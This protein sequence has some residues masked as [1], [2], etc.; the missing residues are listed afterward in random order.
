MLLLAPALSLFALVLIS[1]AQALPFAGAEGSD[2]SRRGAVDGFSE[3][4]PLTHG[5][6][7]NCDHSGPPAELLKELKCH[8]LQEPHPMFFLSE[9]A[10]N[11]HQHRL[12]PI[13]CSGSNSPQV[14]EDT[15]TC[16]ISTMLNYL[17]SVVVPDTE[18]CPP[19]FNITY[20]PNRYPHYFVEV[21]CTAPTDGPHVKLQ[22]CP[23]TSSSDDKSSRLI[24]R[25]G[26]FC[27]S[28]NLRGMRYLTNDP[29]DNGCAGSPTWRTCELQD[30]GIGCTCVHSL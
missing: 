10:E 23:Y 22:R 20:Y 7:C 4:E 2:L 29:H 21:V 25:T 16:V 3:N 9:M 28:Y 26:G 5:Y 15:S 24:V 17:N 12:C 11:I 27:R 1:S 14:E 8:L 19:Q 13:I 30:V 6:G 18:P